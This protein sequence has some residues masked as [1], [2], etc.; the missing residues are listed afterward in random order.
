M[1][2][3]LAVLALAAAAPKVDLRPIKTFST[4]IIGHCSVDVV[5]KLAIED[6]NV[7]DYY[8]PRVEWEWEDGTRST[9]EADCEPFESARPEDHRKTWT[10]SWGAK[11]AGTHV[12]KVR[13]YKG[14][15]LVRIIQTQVRVV[16][17]EGLSEQ[18]RRDAGCPP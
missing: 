9:E 11:T 13:L 10:R 4:L 7:E 12:V 16:G 14:D 3:A 5:L 1:I 15:K 6:H 17:F 18:E 2:A 8:C